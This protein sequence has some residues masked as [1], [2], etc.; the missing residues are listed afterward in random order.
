MMNDNQ[1]EIL[2]DY[3]DSMNGLL[4][5]DNCRKCNYHETYSGTMIPL[6]CYICEER[7]YLP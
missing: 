2:P 7:R 3:I 6:N 1:W 5:H 4:V